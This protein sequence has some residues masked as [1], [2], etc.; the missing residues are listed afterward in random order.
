LL[1]YENVASGTRAYY[2]FSCCEV[3]RLFLVFRFSPR[4][5][6]EY[7]WENT[8]RSSARRECIPNFRSLLQGRMHFIYLYFVL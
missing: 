8:R 5:A 1:V 2:E 6:F 3:S 4:G 7:F